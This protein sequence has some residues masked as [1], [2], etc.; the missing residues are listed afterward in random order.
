[1]TRLAER[2]CFPELIGPADVSTVNQKPIICQSRDLIQPRP[3]V[4]DAC[5]PSHPTPGKLPPLIVLMEA[6]QSRPPGGRVGD[7]VP[8]VSLHEDLR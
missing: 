3:L 6:R 7:T 8:S 1:M 4:V 2:S 5:F